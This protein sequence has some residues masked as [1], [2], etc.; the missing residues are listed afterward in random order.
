MHTSKRPPSKA[1]KPD[2]LLCPHILSIKI[3]TQP[4]MGEDCLSLLSVG[5]ACPPKGNLT[6]VGGLVRR[7]HCRTG[8]LTPSYGMS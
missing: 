6:H 3:T 5:Q 7:R 1:E 4:P 8:T 2:C